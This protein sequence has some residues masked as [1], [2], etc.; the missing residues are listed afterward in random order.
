[1][2]KLVN[3]ILVIALFG[4][5]YHFDVFGIKTKIHEEKIIEKA[6]VITKEVKNGVQNVTKDMTDKFKEGYNT[7]PN[8]TIKKP[9]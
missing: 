9:N 4:A 2:K 7:I 5:L 3:F 6:G 1:M 8:G